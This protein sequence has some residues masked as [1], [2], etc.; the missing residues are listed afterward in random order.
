MPTQTAAKIRR[1]VRKQLIL[2]ALEDG[3]MTADELAEETGT[4]R[5]SVNKLVRALREEDRIEITD[6]TYNP[7][8]RGHNLYALVDAEDGR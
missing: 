1:G 4:P 8:G 7:E 5:R 2:E 3:P 6:T